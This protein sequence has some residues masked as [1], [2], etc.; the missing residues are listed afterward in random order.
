MLERTIRA[1]KPREAVARDP[2]PKV[3]LEPP[4]GSMLD[5]WSSASPQRRPSW[6]PGRPHEPP[7]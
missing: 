2:A 1:P 5:L 4:F 6:S 3:R 7:A